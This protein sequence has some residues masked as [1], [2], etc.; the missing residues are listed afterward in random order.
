MTNF[1]FVLSISKK[2]HLHGID[3]QWY[4][5]IGLFLLRNKFTKGVLL[6][7]QWENALRTLLKK[8][9][10]QRITIS[11]LSEQVNVSRQN[12]Y[13]HYEDKYDLAFS[14]FESK[15]SGIWEEYIRNG[16]YRKMLTELLSVFKEDMWFYNK[17]LYNTPFYQVFLRKWH[18][19]NMT[20]TKFH[21]GTK[22]FSERIRQ[23]AEIYSYGTELYNINWLLGGCKE[24]VEKMVEYIFLSMPAELQEVYF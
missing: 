3:F 2:R 4:N 12:F 18:E 15:A 16:D 20:M 17:V 8:Y 7:D 10:F 21:I 19:S 1:G 23:V 13:R 24:P 9:D 22:S 14:V 5:I 11:M 6:M